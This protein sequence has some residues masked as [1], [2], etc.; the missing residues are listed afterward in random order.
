[1]T[2]SAKQKAYEAEKARLD[3]RKT[4]KN[5]KCTPPNKKCGG[6]CIPPSWDCRLKNEGSDKHLMA[7]KTDPLKGAASIQRG[8]KRLAKGV[9]TG[10]IAEV[11]SGRSTITRGVVTVT[12][13]NL[14]QKKELRQKIERRTKFIGTALLLGVGGFAL[15]TQAKKWRPYKDNVGDK[16]DNFARNGYNTALDRMPILGNIR[17]NNRRAAASNTARTAEAILKRQTKGP[18]ALE[19][20]LSGTG[21]DPLAS[22]QKGDAISANALKKALD[23]QDNYARDNKHDYL[24][25]D[26]ENRTTFLGVTK[27]TSKN[28][29]FKG[30]ELSIYAEPAGEN[31]LRDAYGLK[32]KTGSALRSELGDQFR[33]DREDYFRLAQQNGFKLMGGK[34]PFM[35][36]DNANKF[37]RFA[38]ESLKGQSQVR[39][40]AQD[41]IESLVQKGGAQERANT[42]YRD[43]IKGFSNYFGEA[44]K[45]SESTPGVPI[46]REQRQL[47]EKAD[48]ARARELA[49]RMPGVRLEG[50][51]GPAVGEVVRRGY[52]ATKVVGNKNSTYSVSDR[53]FRSAASELTGRPVNSVTEA[54]QILRNNG[55]TGATYIQT[56]QTRQQDP[57]KKN[58]K[59]LTK[60]QRLRRQS[61]L[62]KKYREQG[63]SPEAAMKAARKEMEERGDGLTAYEINYL[64]ARYDFKKG[65]SKGK[66]CGKSYIPKNHKCKQGP[67]GAQKEE[68]TSVSKAKENT[69]KTEAEES[70]PK[71]TVSYKTF[72]KVALAAG[73]STAAIMVINDGRAIANKMDLP[74][75][76][77]A[78]K[79]YKPFKKEGMKMRDA[80]NAYYDSKVEAEGWKVGDLVYSRPGKQTSGHFGVYLGKEGGVHKF[81]EMAAARGAKAGQFDITDAGVQVFERAPKEYRPKQKSNLSEAEIINRAE[82]LTQFELKYDKLKDNCESWARVVIGDNPRSKQGEKLSPITKTLSRLMER[83]FRKQAESEGWTFDESKAQETAKEV[84]KKLSDLEGLGVFDEMIAGIK[85]RRSTESAGEDLLD[86]L[87]RGDSMDGVLISPEELLDGVDSGVE[88]LMLTRNYLMLN[89]ALL[90]ASRLQK[91]VLEIQK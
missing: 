57:K 54:Q 58:K 22:M 6:R 67:G 15:H 31:F 86:R 73:V 84:A 48:Q 46:I 26:A 23:G 29:F 45:L 87:L 28:D 50:N 55:F 88:R 52:Y 82:M 9:V 7:V 65:S 39:S 33:A 37:A 14:Q 64:E 85:K 68:K 2:D 25:W 19:K 17:E 90:K 72:A 78:K 20:T 79:A 56:A 74:E 60:Q 83:D 5:V 47:V 24:K 30:E 51:V 89:V 3:A 40:A 34:D 70:T 44:T 1:M 8:F 36:A 76:K 11:Q 10:N 63:L 62:A 80:A 13:G 38:T 71:K 91:S 66:A 4:N 27:V 16:V 12:P 32:G 59:K 35:D 81:G 21:A 77:T 41:H 61:E 43:T 42:V 18:A 75:T 49:S 69:T 53:L